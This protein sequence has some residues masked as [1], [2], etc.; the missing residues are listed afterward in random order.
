[1][2]NFLSPKLFYKRKIK[3]PYLISNTEPDFSKVEPE[4]NLQLILYVYVPGGHGEDWPK[5][6]PSHPLLI[7]KLSK[8]ILPH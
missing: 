5:N 7:S 6:I 8:T 3:N 4:V 2:K 1:M